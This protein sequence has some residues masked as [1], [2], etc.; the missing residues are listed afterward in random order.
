[1][2]EP[3]FTTKEVGRGTGLG[4]SMVYG[5]V[6]QSNGYIWCD[7]SAGTGTIFRIAL[8]MVNE[9]PTPRRLATKA[10]HGGASGVVLLAEDEDAI[11]ALARRILEREGYTVLE[12]RDG[13]D[14]LRVAAGYPSP[15]DLLVSDMVMPNLGG[16]ALYAQLCNARP[17]LRALFI[18]G[19]TD[20]DI[21][22]RG[23]SEGGSAFLQKPFT[24]QALAAATAAAL[25]T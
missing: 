5:I 12:A 9:R 22:R 10:N 7:S 17:A 14:A 8:P 21:A 23:L 4:L 16:S 19:Y 11:R 6:K 18:S 1:V 24:A 25:A 13:R 20:D 3:F 15:I 2:F